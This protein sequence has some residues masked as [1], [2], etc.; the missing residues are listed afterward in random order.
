MCVRSSAET[1][2]LY[3]HISDFQQYSFPFSDINSI[4]N[5]AR[6]RV[7]RTSHITLHKGG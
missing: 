4:D 5:N 2:I 6:L 1:N 7:I 3:I